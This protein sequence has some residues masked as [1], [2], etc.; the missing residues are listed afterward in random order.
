MGVMH[1]M[2]AVML[3]VRVVKVLVNVDHVVQMVMGKT[4][5]V[6]LVQSVDVFH[7]IG[8]LVLMP[9]LE[10]RNVKLVNKV[11]LQT[12]NKQLVLLG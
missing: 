1:G 6:K 3:S 8:R 11:T 2:I 10:L 5:I 12:L 9:K 4:F 7:A